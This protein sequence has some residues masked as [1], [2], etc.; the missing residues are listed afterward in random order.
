MFF[1]R[2]AKIAFVLLC[3]TLVLGSIGFRSAVRALNVYL[4]KLPVPLRE[5][6]D[7]IPATLGAW[8]AVAGGSLFRSGPV[9]SF[10]PSELREPG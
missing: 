2:Q 10:K 8:E 4:T 9:P 6:F 5:H 3:L 1:D 7:N